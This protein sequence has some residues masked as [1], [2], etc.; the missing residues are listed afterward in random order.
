MISDGLKKSWTKLQ[1]WTKK[2]ADLKAGQFADSDTNL[3]FF[4]ACIDL[5]S[6]H[7][8]STTS[9]LV[10]ALLTV[11]TFKFSNICLSI[12][13]WKNHFSPQENI[14]GTIMFSWSWNANNRSEKRIRYCMCLHRIIYSVTYITGVNAKKLLNNT[15]SQI[16]GSDCQSQNRHSTK[17][18]SM[19]WTCSWH[20]TGLLSAC[21]LLDYVS[22]KAGNSHTSEIWWTLKMVVY[23]EGGKWCL[24]PQSLTQKFVPCF[25]RC[26]YN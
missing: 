7:I 22:Y 3:L 11:I 8:L 25:L 2:S 1:T 21:L 6:M 18:W 13:I 5:V 9:D 17:I 23:V 26:E 24:G 12:W 10:T 20:A 4:H 15:L 16:T 14:T 19:S